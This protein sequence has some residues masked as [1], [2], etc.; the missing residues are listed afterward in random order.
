MRTFIDLSLPIHATPSE[1]TPVTITPLDHREAPRV[2]GMEPD[3]FPDGMA[4]SN[5][6]VAFTTHT[7]THMD[8]PFHYGPLSG[9]LPARK[10][11][12]IPLSWCYGRG[13]RL[14]V[15]HRGPGE[16]ISEKDIRDAEEKTGTT[17]HP[18]DIVLI[19]T[20]CDSL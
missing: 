12:D 11:G 1:A 20:G 13:I 10:I 7:G 5:E 19:W 8:A 14:D 2:L 17:L 3:D 6:F 4:I 18:L 9:G 16:G 15:R